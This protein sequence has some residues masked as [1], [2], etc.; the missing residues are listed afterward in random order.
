MLV[1]FNNALFGLE[2]LNT[3]P[4]IREIFILFCIISICCHSPTPFALELS[5]NSG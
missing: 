3:A 4:E 2:K 5:G 1:I